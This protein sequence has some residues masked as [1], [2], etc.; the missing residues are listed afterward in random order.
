M[1]NINIQYPI[2]STGK[3]P[4]YDGRVHSITPS[5]LRTFT[6][7][8]MQFYV[9]DYYDNNNRMTTLLVRVGGQFYKVPLTDYN[10]LY[11]YLM[12]NKPTDVSMSCLP[13]KIG[14]TNTLSFRD[15]LLPLSN[16]RD[17]EVVYDFNLYAPVNDRDARGFFRSN[18]CSSE[19]YS[20]EYTYHFEQG[21][22]SARI[23]SGVKAGARMGIPNFDF[24]VRFNPGDTGVVYGQ[25]PDGKLVSYR[26]FMI[27]GVHRYHV[28]YANT[29]VNRFNASIASNLDVKGAS[30]SE[31][32]DLHDVPSAFIDS[33]SGILDQQFYC[34][35]K[36][37]SSTNKIGGRGIR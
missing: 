29:D 14:I 24:N 31:Y 37:F 4:L 33:Y 6:L 34:P 16:R 22:H 32:R 27:P 19:V 7:G 5:Y 17:S 28:T 10:A 15:H 21:V 18:G 13:E 3:N 11:E 25:G 26:V 36:S 35:N 20:D 9:L 1:K 8:G 12:H 2:D 30:C 23:D